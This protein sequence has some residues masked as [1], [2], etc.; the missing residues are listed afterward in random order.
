MRKRVF[1]MI[2]SL[3]MLATLLPVQGHALED[4]EIHQYAREVVG[5]YLGLQNVNPEG[6][7]YLSQ[8][9][10]VTNAEDGSLRVFLLLKKRLV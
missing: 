8:G 9:F 5:Q 7:F 6:E 3:I 10:E 2:L 1:S 4:S